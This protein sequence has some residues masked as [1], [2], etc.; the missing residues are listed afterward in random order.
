MSDL[1]SWWAYPD[2]VT[3]YQFSFNFSDILLF[4]EIYIEVFPLFN[5]FIMLRL[6][7]FLKLIRTILLNL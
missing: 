4:C 5:F 6:L 3:H 2:I 7:C 1:G